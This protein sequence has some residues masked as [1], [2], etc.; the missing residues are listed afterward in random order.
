MAG[1]KHHLARATLVVLV[2]GTIA[3]TIAVTTEGDF[4][5]VSSRPVSFLKTY[6]SE[7]S[8]SFAA[9][10]TVVLAVVAWCNIRIANRSLD[11][12]SE[13]HEIARP[14]MELDYGAARLLDDDDSAA[15]EYAILVRAA[16]RSSEANSLTTCE[17]RLGLGR[18]GTPTTYIVLEAVTAHRVERP[19]WRDNSEAE[20]LVF[21]LD[22]PPFGSAV[23]WVL[24]RVP[25]SLIADSVPGP[26]TL[27][28][29][30]SR[31]VV[32]P[33][34]VFAVHHTSDGPET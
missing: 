5:V 29:A 10:A 19:W 4:E 2:L 23:G 16:N 18:V 9:L 11:I 1:W 32:A 30:A 27:L 26:P 6:V 15:R 24:F 7:W 20:M 33:L 28:F 14:N 17:L 8:A 31:G 22:L 34:R 25:A 3:G 21:P 12:L 13:R